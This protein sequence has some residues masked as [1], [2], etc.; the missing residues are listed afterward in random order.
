SSVGPH[1][2]AFEQELG[3]VVGAHVCAL[4]SGTAALHLALRLV[5]VGP[6]DEVFCPTLTF[7]ATA[8][9]IVYQG[10]R[11][12]FLDSER[13]SWNLDPDVLEQALAAKAAVGRLPKAIIVVHLFGQSAD[14]DPILALARRYEIPVVEDAAEAL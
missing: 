6:G 13:T 4:S 12:V 8:N 10:A 1:V 11:P 5:G 7:V 3:R 14:L 2:D 9:P